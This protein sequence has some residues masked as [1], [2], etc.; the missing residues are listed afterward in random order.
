L[1]R[2]RERGKD[3]VEKEVEKEEGR[4]EGGGRQS[5]GE[6]VREEGWVRKEERYGAGEVARIGIKDGERTSGR[7]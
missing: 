2:G 5:S 4:V 7:A 6:G 3:E 1:R